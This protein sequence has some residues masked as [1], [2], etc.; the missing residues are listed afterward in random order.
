MLSSIILGWFLSFN[1]SSFTF[2]SPSLIISRPD[3]GL[4]GLIDFC[5]WARGVDKGELYSDRIKTRPQYN[6]EK[7]D[8]KMS[9]I[10]DVF[11]VRKYTKAFGSP[12]WGHLKNSCGV[13]S[14][15]R[16][17]QWMPWCCSLITQVK[18]DR[19]LGRHIALVFYCYLLSCGYLWMFLGK[20]LAVCPSLTLSF[21]LYKQNQESYDSKQF[22]PSSA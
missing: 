9:G 14:V 4:P 12:P 17:W 11:H 19:T 5:S 3:G 20:N 15:Q 6:H 13:V 21:V 22:L 7:I 18:T 8:S 16:S 10:A 2:N 1:H